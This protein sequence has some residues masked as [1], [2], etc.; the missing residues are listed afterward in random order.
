MRHRSTSLM[1]AVRDALTAMCAVLLALATAVALA[2]LVGSPVAPLAV[3][4]AAAA[5]MLSGQRGGDP[6]RGGLASAAAFAVLMAAG[7]WITWRMPRQPVVGAGLFVALM[8]VS[9]WARRFGARAVRLGAMV[10]R[11][12]LVALM[13]PHS[14]GARGWW[15]AG[16]WV[17]V[18]GFTAFWWVHAVRWAGRR[19]A[20]RSGPARRPVAPLPQRRSV[21]LLV[22]TRAAVQT[23][24]AL[25]A[26]FAVGHRLFAHHWQ[27]TVVTALVVGLGRGGRGDLALR[28]VERGAGA[29]AGALLAAGL[30]VV[31][32]PHGTLGLVVIFA[33]LATA[34]GF[35]ARSYALFTATLTTLMSLLHE[36]FGHS[37]A[38]L[39][40]IRFQAVAVGAALAVAVGWFVAPVRAGEVLRL[41]L[42]AA[43]RALAAL[44][45][46]HHSG[47]PVDVALL[48]FERAADAVESVAR[49][50]RIYRRLL[51]T[52]RGRPHRADLADALHD[53]RAPVRALTALG[54]VPGHPAGAAG[55]AATVTALRHWLADPGTALGL[56]HAPAAEWPL[57]D[58]DAAL[59]RLGR[60]LPALAPRQ[61]QPAARSADQAE[62]DAEL[63]SS[64]SRDRG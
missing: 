49:P 2:H 56:R 4:G 22:S 10:P 32:H 51:G 8:T 58:L 31:V 20:G 16:C 48:R 57:A 40:L 24:V 47:T 11:A 34:A 9:V 35:R 53:C 64:G 44:L 12:L 18:I 25:T 37:A 46:A 62:P 33:V 6:W 5:F 14:G 54:A 63:K 50:H 42:T 21:G 52:R 30:A 13:T 19:M 17:A 28:G 60:A 15:P 23:G 7:T 26:A 59:A 38:H 1:R 55:T 45:D 61:A 29:M 43:L 41:R 3:S 39:L 27:W 36:Y